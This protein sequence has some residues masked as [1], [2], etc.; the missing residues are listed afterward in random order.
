MTGPLD[1]VNLQ[2]VDSVEKAGQFKTWLGERRNIMGVDTET[3]GFDHIRD[4]LR[5][6]Q[7]GDRNNGWAI[8][9]ERWGG[10]ALEALNEYD[11]PMV[12]HNTPFDAK[13]IIH[14][15][16]KDLKRWK[17]EWMNDTMTMAHLADPLRPKGLKPLAALHIDSR[18]ASSQQMLDSA[19]VDNKWTWA[20]VPV[21]FPLYWIYGA[22]DPVLTVHLYDKFSPNVFAENKEVYQLEMATLRVVTNMMLKGAKVDLDYTQQKFTE[23][24]HW[25]QEART[26][27]S[28]VYKID[29]ATSSQQVIKAF[30]REGVE[31]PQVYTK[32]G[33]QS[34]DKDVLKTIIAETQ[35]PIAT[36]VLAIR[37]AEKNTGP[38]FKNFLAM[39]DENDRVHPTIWAMGTRTARMSI[40]QPALQTLPRKDP[41]VRNAFIPSEGNTLVTCD[42]DQVEAR[43][44]AHFADDPGMIAAFAGTEDFFVALARQIFLDQ[45]LVKGD[46]RRQLTKNVVYGKLYGAGVEKMAA[47]AGVPFTQMAEV[48]SAFER[49]FPQVKQLQNKINWTAR[50]RYETEGQAYIR[51]PWNRRLVADDNKEYTLTN[52]LIQSHAAEILKRKMIELDAA[53]LGEYMIL[54]VHDEILFDIPTDIAADAMVTIGEVMQDLTSYR[55]PIT[56]TPELIVGAWGSKYELPPVKAH[57]KYPKS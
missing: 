27:L 51:T 11:A 48:V 14:N 2:L 5:L 43:L 38:Y 13:Y 30:E 18:A 53:D 57:D 46:P 17:W 55:V 9:W 3:G 7:F 22:L 33:A 20:T 56:A 50:Q 41:T 49:T 34:L 31:L 54:P 1:H 4:K 39:A 24:G 40:T 10:V 23:L 52:Y 25:S 47:T 21:D 29:N 6:V 19:M 36:Y 15:G 12:L 35:H 28:D 42:Y 26:W 32:A 16:G 8:P 45:T 44:V 37:Q